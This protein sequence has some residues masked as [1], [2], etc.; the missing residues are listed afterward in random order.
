[1]YELLTKEENQEINKW[2]KWEIN[3]YKEYIIKKIKNKKKK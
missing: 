2:K 1:M 3:S